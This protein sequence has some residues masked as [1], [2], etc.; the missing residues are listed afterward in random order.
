MSKGK[1]SRLWWAVAATVCL[2]AAFLLL[3][4]SLIVQPIVRKVVRSSLDRPELGLAC[5]DVMTDI[6]WFRLFGRGAAVTVS[7]RYLERPFDV[8]ARFGFGCSDGLKAWA[9]VGAVVRNTAWKVLAKGDVGFGGWQ[10]EASLAECAFDER[11]PLLVAVLGRYQPTSVSNLVFSGSVG[12]TAV[13]SR[14]DGA[15]VMTWKAKLPVRNLS[16][17]LVCADKAIAVGNLALTVS[18]SGVGSHFD[19]DPTRVMA[20]SISAAGVSLENFFAEVRADRDDVMVTEA[21]AACYGGSVRLYALHLKPET[22]SGGFSLYLENVEAGAVLAQFKGFQGD[23]SGLLN[24]KLSLFF[25]DGNRL[26][27]RDAY[28]QSPSGA[29]GKLRL[30]ESAPIGDSLALAGLDDATRNNVRRALAN[31]DYS[32]LK[33][34]IRREPDRTLA[35]NVR[36]EGTATRGNVS[37]PVSLNITFRGDLE[38]LINTGLKLTGQGKDKSK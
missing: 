28:L 30:D 13:A 34:D 33:L 36:I 17:N 32:V 31:L 35:L 16:A 29:V 10:A 18:A 6:Y 3:L 26:R 25:A 12:G 9:R 14:K 8:R 20:R 38:Q 23:C 27:I 21:G 37:A 1:K 19:V 2:A 7:G 22:L 4:P 5:D 11:D 15:G 24:G